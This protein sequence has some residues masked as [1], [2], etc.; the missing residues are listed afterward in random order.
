M[1][2]SGDRCTVLTW[3]DLK[4]RAA[5]VFAD[6]AVAGD[7]LNTSNSLLGGQTPH[8]AFDSGEEDR[9]EELLT[10]IEYGIFS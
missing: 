3:A 1:S 7:W 9:V 4:S 6:A 5:E 10:R 2:P 8:Q